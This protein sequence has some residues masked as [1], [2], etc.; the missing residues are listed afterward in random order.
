MSAVVGDLVVGAHVGERPGQVLEVGLHGW[1][2]PWRLG[3]V[4]LDRLAQV[5]HVPELRLLVLLRRDVPEDIKK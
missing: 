4:E 1:G 2:R 5:P 3:G